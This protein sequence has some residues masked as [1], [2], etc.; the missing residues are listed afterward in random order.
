ML[1]DFCPWPRAL[2]VPEGKAAAV[3]LFQVSPQLCEEVT[4]VIVITL[5]QVR[6]R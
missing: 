6:P 1:G 4:K 2:F 3:H 5:Q